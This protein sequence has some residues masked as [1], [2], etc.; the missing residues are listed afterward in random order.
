MIFYFSGTGNSKYIATRLSEMLHQDLIS[1]NEKIKNNDTHPISTDEKLIFVT[2][3]YGWRL[4]KIVND[5]ITAVNFTNGKKVWFILDCGD[6][7]AN[8]G[9]YNKK[10]CDKKNLEYKGTFQI[11]MPENY[12]ALFNAPENQQAKEIILKAEPLIDKAS[13]IIAEGNNFPS[14]S[15]NLANMF[16]SDIINPFFYSTIIK[17]KPFYVTDKCVGCGKCASLCPLNNIT[18]QNNKPSWSNKCTHCMS[19]ICYCPT[20]AIEY[21]NSAKNKVRYNFENLNYDRKELV[22]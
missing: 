15:N 3:P 12:I 13:E 1:I 4:P 2:P 14:V 10:L 16:L 20:Q 22:K 18:I 19:C 9:K 21:G 17:A 5:W 8:A 7:I 6:S 11:I